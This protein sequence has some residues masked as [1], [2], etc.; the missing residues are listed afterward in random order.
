M[1]TLRNLAVH[2]L[3]NTASLVAYKRLGDMFG[4]SADLAKT[5]VNYLQEAFLFHLLPLYRMKA[6]ERVRNPDKVHAG[7]AGVRK[8][9]QLSSTPDKG[10]LLETHVHNHLLRQYEEGLFYWKQS[11]EV[12]FIIRRG[13]SIC[14]FVQVAYGN[15]DE[16]NLL[17]REIRSLQEGLKQYAQAKAYLIVW[18]VPKN[19]DEKRHDPIVLLPFWQFLLSD[20]LPGLPPT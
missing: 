18:E 19:W 7:D 11:G 3:R 20:C 5:Y 16:P 12:D 15:L 6:A 9:V 4:V 2:L 1:A 13:N 14:G 8:R 10:K 17:K